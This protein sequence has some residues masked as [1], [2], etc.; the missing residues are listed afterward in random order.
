MLLKTFD[1]SLS[2]TQALRAADEG[3]YDAALAR[4]GEVSPDSA[5]LD[6]L[7]GVCPPAA[8]PPQKRPATAPAAVAAKKAKAGTELEADR[9]WSPGAASKDSDVISQFDVADGDVPVTATAAGWEAKTASFTLWQPEDICRVVDAAVNLES[10]I[11]SGLGGKRDLAVLLAGVPEEVRGHFDVLVDWECKLAE[12]TCED[13]LLLTRQVSHAVLAVAEEVQSWWNNE[14][15][16]ARAERGSGSR[17]RGH[18]QPAPPTQL[19]L[20]SSDSA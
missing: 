15:E 16:P 2:S 10:T 3:V 9:T 12:P 18:V 11:N 5:E 4:I 19:D 7:V 14:T 1:T 13:L 20:Q 8:K 17:S 6:Q